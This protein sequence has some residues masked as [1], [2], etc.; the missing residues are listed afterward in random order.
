MRK[1][2]VVVVPAEWGGRDANKCFL[3]TEMS[4]AEAEKWAW[5][6]ALCVKGTAAQIPESIAGLGMIAV[7]V[8]GINSFFAHDVDEKKLLGLF[9]EMM[10]CVQVV[11]DPRAIDGTTGRPV[12]TPIVSADDIEEVRTIMWLRSEV[13]RVHTNFSFI[14]AALAW[15]AKANKLMASSDT[16][17][18]PL[19]TD[20][21]SAAPPN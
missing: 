17:T 12:A 11:R 16:P 15:I 19:S 14:D 6:L 10:V 3:I 8:R 5:R 21:S 13:L 20:Q 2:E 1:T 18:S 4:A 7:A 9:D